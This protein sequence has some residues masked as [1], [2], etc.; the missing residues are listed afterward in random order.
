MSIDEEKIDTTIAR[1]EEY[2]S[3]NKKIGTCP[4]CKDDL[5]AKGNWE[6]G[7]KLWCMNV[8]CQSVWIHESDCG[9]DY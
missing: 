8:N 2:Y 9:K 6:D 7:V 5:V 3:I 4:V 1:P